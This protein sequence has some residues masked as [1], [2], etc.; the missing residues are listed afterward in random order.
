MQFSLL[1]LAMHNLQF[2]VLEFLISLDFFRTVDFCTKD[3]G[4]KNNK[5]VHKTITKA[6]FKI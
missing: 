5:N 4:V 3:L 6:K 2:A 1:K